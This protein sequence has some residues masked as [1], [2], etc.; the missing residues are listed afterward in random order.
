MSDFFC[1]EK[2]PEIP[3]QFIRNF[4]G[5]IEFWIKREDLL[6]EKVSGNKFRKLKYNLVEAEKLDY[7]TLLSFGGAHSNHISALAAAG[8][9]GNFKTLGIIRGEE[10]EGDHEKWSPTL[11]FAHSCGMKFKFVSR[12]DYRDKNTEG[13]LKKLKAEFGPFYLLP[14][15]GTNELA[16]KGCEEILKPADDI[17]DFIAV[18]VGTGGTI[19]GLI[20]AS[21]SHQK[22]IG[23]PALKTD[24][25]QQ[26]VEDHVNKSNWELILNYHF[27]GY[28]K[29]NAELIAFLN[30]FY[31]DYQIKLDPVYTGKLVFGIFELIKQGFFPSESKILAIHTGGLQ[32]IEAMNQIL[33]KKKQPQINY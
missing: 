1:T 6:H 33:K 9:I 10:L 8:K 4:P 28:A 17:F 32:G 15:G 20:N 12:Q 18:S 14:E 24:Y 19:C 21:A 16:I 31:K 7:D 23:F 26:E 3:N 13:F 30:E 22:I 11:K 2:E 5:N 27:G 25:L 29:A